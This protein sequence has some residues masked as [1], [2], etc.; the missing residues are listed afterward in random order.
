LSIAIETAA[1][2]LAPKNFESTTYTLNLTFSSIAQL[3]ALRVKMDQ[4]L[5][6]PGLKHIIEGKDFSSS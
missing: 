3:R 4:L 2:E 5:K 1:K 6:H